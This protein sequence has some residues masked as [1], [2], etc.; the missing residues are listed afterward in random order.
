MTQDSKE[1]GKNDEI[2]NDIPDE[3]VEITQDDV[4]REI[5]LDD[6]YDGAVNNTVVID[7]VTNNE[8]LMSS[9]K[10]NYTLIGI[11][12]AIVILLGLYYINNKTDLGGTTKEVESKTTKQTVSTSKI[13]NKGA[14]TCTY[15]SK[16]DAE[17]QNITYVANYV[18]NK[19]INSNFNYVVVSNND[20]SSAVIEDLT[21]QYETFFINNAAATSNNVSFDKNEK[22]FTFNVETNYEKDGYDNLVVSEGQ[23]VLFVKPS[24]S[25]TIDT[26]QKSYVSKGFTCN[27]T[28]DGDVNE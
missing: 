26:L 11:I 18:D 25:D 7:P 28:Y 2:I 16:S 12:F 15:T 9:K 19:V 27:I 8:V 13:L 10:P 1:P 3:E 21:N 14:L 17:T 6:L 20:S 24:A 22:G 4:T 5:N 23:T